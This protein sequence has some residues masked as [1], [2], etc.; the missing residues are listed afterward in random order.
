MNIFPKFSALRSISMRNPGLKRLITW[1][2]LLGFVLT[3][4]LPAHASES[5][6]RS[7]VIPIFESAKTVDYD[8]FFHKF[9]PIIEGAWG[10]E[11]EQESRENDL[12]ASAED[13]YSYSANDELQTIRQLRYGGRCHSRYIHWMANKRFFILADKSSLFLFLF[14]ALRAPC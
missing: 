5:P 10:E 6:R 13:G 2:L 9:F 4:L 3:A 11:N 7:T 8:D 1:A 14:H 12:D